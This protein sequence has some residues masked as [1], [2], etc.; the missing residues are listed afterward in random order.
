MKVDVEELGACKRRLQVEETPEVVQQAW[1]RAFTQ[2]QR[3][4]KLPGFRKGKVPRSMIKLHF[5]DDVRQ[6]VARH[7]IPEVYRQALA[8]SRLEPVEEPDL[9]DLTLE[10]SAPLKFSAVV[11]IKPTI[12]L[13][14]YAGVA[15]QHT[16]K[17]L[18][19][20]EVEEALAN[21]SEQH[22]EYRAVERPADVGDLVIVDYTLTPDGMEARSE[23]GYGVVIGSG[24]VMKEVDEALIGLAPGGERQ[25]RVRFPDDHR[26]EALRGVGGDAH[27]KVNEVKEKVLPALDDEFAK[28]VGEFETLDALRAEIRSGLEKR[29]EQEN[30]RTLENAVLEA[31][32]AEHTFDVPEA[33]VVRQVGHQIEHIREQ[34]RRQGMDPERVPWDYQK[35]LGDMRPGAEK[36]VKRALL[37]EAIA[38]KEGLEATDADVEAEI[39]RFAQA[40]QR[41]AAAVRAMF[42]QSG[43]LSRIRASLGEKRTLDFLIERAAIT[44]EVH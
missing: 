43:D 36:A 3:Q 1:E 44:P 27:V 32:L 24:A 28:T 10:E 31:A 9:S 35:L 20:A 30:R 12:A 16:Q 34:M 8:E 11:E 37:I 22:A 29:R 17:P 23:S 41:P 13:G 15:V 25:T 26:N 7:L 21:L 6:E 18:T 40:S 19:D 14:Q 33:L 2:V 38:E 39:E 42:E 4:A 5:S